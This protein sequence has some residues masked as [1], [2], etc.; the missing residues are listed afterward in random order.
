MAYEVATIGDLHSGGDARAVRRPFAMGGVAE[1]V[2]AHG[3]P[4]VVFGAGVLMGLAF[5][6]VLFGGRRVR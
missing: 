3:G 1:V 5:G 4:Y 2:A 6:A